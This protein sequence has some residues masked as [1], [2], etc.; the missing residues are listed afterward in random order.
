MG[1]VTKVLDTFR[2][3]KCVR[4]F[5]GHKKTP[6]PGIS[7]SNWS[8]KQ[9]QHSYVHF[10][11]DLRALQ[12][13]KIQKLVPENSM[14]ADYLQKNLSADW[15]EILKSCKAGYTQHSFSPL[16]FDWLCSGKRY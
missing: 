6:S 10:K 5:T 7:G 8:L 3:K 16:V 14:F 15:Q 13:L 12:L 11:S 2:K 4:R 1:R 9:L